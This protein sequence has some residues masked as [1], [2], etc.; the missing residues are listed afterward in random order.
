MQVPAALP[1][2]E[3]S[4]YLLNRKLSGPQKRFGHFRTENLHANTGNLTTIPWLS[5]PAQP[6]ARGLHVALGDI[7]N[8]KMAFNPFPA[9][10]N[11]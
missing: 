9:K 11:T 8:Y 7:R 2:G 3:C 4:C 6:V 5:R 10:A 1:P